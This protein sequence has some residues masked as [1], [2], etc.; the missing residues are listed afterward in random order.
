[1]RRLGWLLVMLWAVPAFSADR[2][3]SPGGN[4]LNSCLVGLPCKTLAKAL[5]VRLPAERIFLAAGTYDFSS[6]EKVTLIGTN[7]FIVTPTGTVPLDTKFTLYQPFPSP[8]TADVQVTLK[9]GQRLQNVR[10]TYRKTDSSE[11]V[12]CTVNKSTKVEIVR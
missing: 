4:D 12:F 5:S 6:V 11:T 1:V 10:W 2:F 7:V 3:V 8:L 9:P